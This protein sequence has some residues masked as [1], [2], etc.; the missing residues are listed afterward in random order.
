[1]RKGDRFP[2]FWSPQAEE[3]LLDIWSF[4]AQESSAETADKLLREIDHACFALGAWPEYGRVRNE[5]REGL[6][7][8]RVNRYVV[9]YRVKKSAIQIVR[10]LDERRDVDPLFSE[11]V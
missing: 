8:V 5:V 10:V 2:R 1:M 3:D 11:E 7:S 6:R 4:V 9:F